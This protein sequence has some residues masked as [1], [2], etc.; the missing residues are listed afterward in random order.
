[1][2]LP[3]GGFWS[4]LINVLT[5][6]VDKLKGRALAFTVATAFLTLLFQLIM[7]LA[8]YF[9]FQVVA[10][11]GMSFF[12]DY[13]LP[14]DFFFQISAVASIKIISWSITVTRYIFEKAGI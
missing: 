13:F 5:W 9:R 12:F 3:K 4:L 6:L 1:M 7:T 8:A 10:P 2:A 11:A 14:T